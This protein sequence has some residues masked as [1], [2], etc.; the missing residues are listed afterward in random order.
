M[1]ETG[2]KGLI[3]DLLGCKIVTADG[4]RLGHVLDIELSEGP[5]YKVKT[6]LFG[7]SGLQHRLHLLNPFRKERHK[8]HLPQR[9]PP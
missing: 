3:T 5:H 7:A 1:K 2:S 6:L 4:K 8:P 9:D